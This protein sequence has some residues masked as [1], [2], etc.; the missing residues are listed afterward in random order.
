M[1]I[2]LWLLWIIQS[3][4]LWNASVYASVIYVRAIWTTTACTYS[5]HIFSN[6]YHQ[7]AILN[8]KNTCQKFSITEYIKGGWRDCEKESRLEKM[9]QYAPNEKERDGSRESGLRRKIVHTVQ[10]KC[11]NIFM[12]TVSWYWN[13]IN[14]VN[15]NF[16]TIIIVLIIT[17]LKMYTLPLSNAS[18]YSASIKS[19]VTTNNREPG[20]ELE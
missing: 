6:N 12:H 19:F 11:E 15:C 10:C 4:S 3:C 5:I 9:S 18:I 8:M 14:M 17:I 7:T 1:F 13:F 20:N 16:R 2:F